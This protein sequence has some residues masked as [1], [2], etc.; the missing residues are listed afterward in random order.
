M[1]DFYLL[2]YRSR[3]N[4]ACSPSTSL[5]S[6][7]QFPRNYF[8]NE[9]TKNQLPFKDSYNVNVI[10]KLSIRDIPEFFPIADLHRRI[11]ISNTFVRNHLKKQPCKLSHQN[12]RIRRIRNS[13]FLFHI[14]KHGY[15]Q[16]IHTTVQY[17]P[18]VPSILSTISFITHTMLILFHSGP[19][20][21]LQFVG[22]N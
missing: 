10:S 14:P 1:R 2:E 16:S 12:S 4:V 20:I 15:L 9:I 8:G 13:A 3:Y 18:S 6:N 5:C 19:S 17:T 22:Y 11:D 7:N 21:P